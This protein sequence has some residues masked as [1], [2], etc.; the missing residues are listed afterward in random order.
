MAGPFY[1]PPPPPPPNNGSFGLPNDPMSGRKIPSSVHSRPPHAG[2]N[3]GYRQQ[4]HVTHP[5]SQAAS[6]PPI[7]NHGA[8]SYQTPS[9]GYQGAPTS[10]PYGQD[11]YSG[12]RTSAPTN[13]GY[14]QAY[15][16]NGYN[17]NTNPQYGAHGQ[18]SWNPAQHY[19]PPAQP[20]NGAAYPNYSPASVPQQPPNPQY[21]PPNPAAAQA[22][23]NYPYNN[24]PIQPTPPQSGFAYA[25]P[26]PPPPPPPQPAQVHAQAQ[27]YGNGPRNN[28]NRSNNSHRRGS[29]RQHDAGR[30]QKRKREQSPSR[31]KSVNSTV[32]GQRG[33]HQ[34]NGKHRLKVQVPAPPPV[35]V[36]GGIHALPPKPP[37]V[38]PPA[39]QHQTTRKKLLVKKRKPNTLGLNPSGDVNE[40]SDIDEEAV[41]AASGAAAQVSHN[42]QTFTFNS[43]ADIKSWLSQRKERFPTSERVAARKDRIEKRRQKKE[44]KKLALQLA[45][46]TVS[47]SDA[48]PEAEPI[49]QEAP[50]DVAKVVKRPRIDTNRPCRYFVEHGAC[51][52]KHCRFQHR[53]PTLEERLKIAEEGSEL[54]RMLGLI[55]NMAAK[56]FFDK[57]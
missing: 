4:G 28:D 23:P 29:H 18:T 38:V 36:F 55:K 9:S 43:P 31:A 34:P 39:P 5:R 47:D 57:E 32:L 49:K 33:N 11:A 50:K 21:Y 25:A 12:Y 44:A 37:V 14:A 16:Q 27:G 51:Q 2:G 45:K 41:F 10:M 40:D 54:L 19:T 52:R 13:I 20:M 53:K 3:R 26:P 8:Q 35:P 56:G 30:G 7:P 1:P 46:S 22:Y 17:A 15:N 42:G 6:H 24:Y 48:P